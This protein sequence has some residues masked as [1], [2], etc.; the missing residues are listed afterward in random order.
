VFRCSDDSLIGPFTARR[1][2]RGGS[3]WH[4]EVNHFEALHPLLLELGE[5]LP[6]M[7]TL[8]VQ[9]MVGENGPVP[10]EFNAR[11]S[12]TTAVRAYFG[13]NEPEMAIRHFVL[14]ETIP[15]PSIRKG[16]A[17]RYLEEVFLNDVGADALG[18]PFVK[19]RVEPWF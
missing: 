16:M 2:L 17:F 15:K 4:V 10:F 1:T 19:G 5:K 8:N 13:F 12:G 14:G 11:F 3:S 18:E 6:S 9:L 7:G